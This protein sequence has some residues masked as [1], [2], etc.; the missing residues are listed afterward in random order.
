MGRQ[1]NYGYTAE[2]VSP[3]LLLMM[4]MLGVEL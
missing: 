2:Y 4:L 1:V 3:P